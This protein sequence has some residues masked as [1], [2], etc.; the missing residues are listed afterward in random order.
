MFHVLRE[1]EVGAAVTKLGGD[2]G[3][4]WRRNKR[5]LQILEERLGRSRVVRFLFGRGGNTDHTTDDEN[6]VVDQALRQTKEEMDQEDKNGQ[7]K[8]VIRGGWKR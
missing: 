5:L 1:S 3:K 4:V 7:E 8:E 2:P 6:D